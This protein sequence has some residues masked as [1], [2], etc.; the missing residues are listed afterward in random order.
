MLQRQLSSRALPVQYR[1]ELTAGTSLPVFPNPCQANGVQLQAQL[2][3][4][5]VELKQSC[6]FPL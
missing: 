2:Q 1:S 6:T 5:W 3:A 4:L